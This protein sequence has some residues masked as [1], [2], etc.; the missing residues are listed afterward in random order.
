MLVE[1][2]KIKNQETLGKFSTISDKNRLSV[3]NTDWTLKLFYLHFIG[4]VFKL[5]G[6]QTFKEENITCPTISDKIFCIAAG[7]I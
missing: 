7:Q 4:V 5:A 2:R 1:L 3:S 6:M